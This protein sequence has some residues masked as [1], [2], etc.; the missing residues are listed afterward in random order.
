MQGRGISSIYFTESS[1][2]GGRHQSKGPQTPARSQT[3]SSP[4]GR[5]NAMT[6]IH[7]VDIGKATEIMKKLLSFSDTRIDLLPQNIRSDLENLTEMIGLV[8]ST[9]YY[10]EMVKAIQSVFGS[11]KTVKP[12]TVG[13]VFMGCFLNDDYPGLKQCSA[14]CAGMVPSIG[15]NKLTPCNENVL[16]YNGVTFTSQ[17]ETN[18]KT[19]SAIIH[20]TNVSSFGGFSASDVKKLKDH[21]IKYVTLYF[22]DNNNKYTEMMKKQPVDAM[23]NF[24]SNKQQAPVQG[25]QP[26]A[27]QSVGQTVQPQPIYSNDDNGNVWVWVLF[28]FFALAIIGLLIWAANRRK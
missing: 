9:D 23:I 20:V 5:G 4:S 19:D 28:F 22:I 17:T 11:I 12:E 2:R 7:R 3:S 21:G 6:D 24:G 15:G 8:A 1:A 10:P 13:A 16:T 27:Q 14:T 25:A 26:P 18:P